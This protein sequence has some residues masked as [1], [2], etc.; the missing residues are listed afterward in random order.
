MPVVP[1]IFV[2]H[3]SYMLCLNE[4]SSLSDHIVEEEGEFIAYKMTRTLVANPVSH[5]G[6]IVKK[7]FVD[8]K[9]YS[10]TIS[11]HVCSA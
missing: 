7:L 10:G 3:C 5:E 9:T 4:P 11:I 8:G 1:M 2:S 6:L